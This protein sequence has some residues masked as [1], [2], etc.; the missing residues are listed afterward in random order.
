MSRDD[1]SRRLRLL[2]T[3]AGRRVELIAAFRQSAEALGIGL[4][5]IACDARS[6]MS[7]ACQIADMAFDV[8]SASGADYVPALIDAVERHG[9]DLVV[10][11]IDPELLPLAQAKTMFAERGAHVAISD[12][13]LV[14]MAGDKLA[15]AAFL[16]EHRIPSPATMS[17]ETALTCP[18]AW[19]GAMF[20]KPRF[21]SAGRNTQPVGDHAGLALLSRDEPML[22]QALLRGTEYTVNVFFDRQ[23]AL[24]AVVPHQRLSVRAGEVEKGVTVREPALLALAEQLAAVLPGP[25][26][27]L[28]FQ[29]MIDGDGSAAMFE[30]NARFGGGYPLAHRAGATFTRWLL[31]E[32]LGLAPTVAGWREGV[33]MM[34]YDAAVFVG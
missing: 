31:E 28:C 7:A 22:V 34:R 29:A 8:P 4:D 19:P 24:R 30:I 11:T 32:R 17:L 18:G 25:S 2:V 23:G 27:A 20:A 26:G 14:A 12:P 6:A 33:T 13:A 3:S 1:P 16:A 5:V 15:T 9:I 21:G 10:P